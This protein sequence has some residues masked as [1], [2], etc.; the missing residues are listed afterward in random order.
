MEIYAVSSVAPNIN[1]LD[2]RQYGSAAQRIS[3]FSNFRC[4]QVFLAR[5]ARCSHNLAVQG[6]LLCGY[7]K[8]KIYE[9][10]PV[11][12]SDLKQRIRIPK[13][14]IQRVMT[15]FP[16]RLHSALDMVVTYKSSLFKQQ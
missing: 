10:R 12:I 16:P 1:A 2:D 9:T 14:M 6:Y 5:Q 4:R 11:N 15:R 7:V 3:W 8:S 13:E